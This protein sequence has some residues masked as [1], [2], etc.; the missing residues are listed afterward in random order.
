VVIRVVSENGGNTGYYKV[1]LVFG[2]TDASL[3]TVSIGGASIGTLPEANSVANGDI[4]VRYQMSGAGPW[5]SV[6]VAATAT[7][8]KAVVT[9]APAATINT[10]IADASWSD[11]GTLSDIPSG[12]Y[13]FIR[14]TSESGIASY[15]K[16]RLVYG[17]GE[18]SL[19][20]VTVG[21]ATATVGTPGGFDMSM[22]GFYTGVAGAVTLTAEQA[23]DG[24]TVTVAATASTGATVRYNWGGGM[25]FGFGFPFYYISGDANWNTTGQDLFKGGMAGGFISVPAGVNGAFIVI[26]VTSEDGT[27]V[28]TYAVSCAVGD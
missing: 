22:G 9:Y 11:S 6:V 28:N 26:E 4:A 2:D 12:Q 23:G 14:V 16:V 19:S 18:A 21:G 7:S 17:S 13:V 20:S 25:D 5:T 15:Y 24:S 1:R 10:P 27:T 3:K 8:N